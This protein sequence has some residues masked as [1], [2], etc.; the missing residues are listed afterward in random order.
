[1]TYERIG[2][3][4]KVI[5][6]NTTPITEFIIDADDIVVVQKE[7]WHKTVFGYICNGPMIPLHRIIMGAKSNE[8]VDHISGDKTD[9]RKCNLRLCVHIENSWNKNAQSNNTSGYKGVRW[10]NRKNKWMSRI[11]ANKTDIFLG[12]FDDKL[13]AAKAYNEA[14]LKYHGEFAKLNDIRDGEVC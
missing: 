12:Y 2:D 1:M 8:E 4:Y 9:N 14:A 6:V 7:W 11:T 10:D 13:E 5:N 3:Y